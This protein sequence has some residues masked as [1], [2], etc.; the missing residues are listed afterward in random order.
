M[1]KRKY[2][3]MKCLKNPIDYLV[4]HM[5]HPIL[6]QRIYKST[7]FLGKI[8]VY[9]LRARKN[10]GFLIKIKLHVLN[11]EFWQPLCSNYLYVLCE[12]SGALVRS[13]KWQCRYIIIIGRSEISVDL[14][15]QI[16]VQTESF[17]GIATKWLLATFSSWVSVVQLQVPE[18]HVSL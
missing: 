12:I 2:L 16:G 10:L 9:F 14:L 4:H 13:A 5:K 7:I 3:S 11:N 6:N 15:T 18:V 1:M 8:S 17:T